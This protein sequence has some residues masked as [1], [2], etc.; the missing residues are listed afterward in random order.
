MNFLFY[1]HVSDPVSNLNILMPVIL[2]AIVGFLALSHGISFV[3]KK[4]YN[5]TISL[6]TGFVVGSLIIIW[7]WKIPLKT[8]LGRS[9]ELKVVSYDWIFPD[10]SLA[11]NIYCFILIFL[12]V[13]AV[14]LIEYLGS[15][16]NS[17]PIN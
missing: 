15:K 12:G 10:V 9:G 4:F 8:I 1:E 7:P 5:S 2:G 11:E 13:F 6:L 17:N 3:L 14:W 16:I